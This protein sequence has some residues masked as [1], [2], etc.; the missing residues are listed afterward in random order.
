MSQ[1]GKRAA[2]RMHRTKRIHQSFPLTL[3]LGPAGGDPH[4][5]Y[6]TLR[7]LE[8]WL[9]EPTLRMRTLAA[10]A[11][12]AWPPSLQLPLCRL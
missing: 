2:S 9:A 3:E 4:A 11:H 7:R 5:P 12:Q 8:V 6:L 1:P 10:L